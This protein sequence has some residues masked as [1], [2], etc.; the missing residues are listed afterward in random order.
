MKKVPIRTFILCSFGFSY[1]LWGAAWL[2]TLLRR[3]TAEDPAVM[4]LMLLGS[5]GPSVGAFIAGKSTGRYRGIRTFLADAFR[6][7]TKWI[8]YLLLPVFLLLYYLFPLLGGGI[9]AGEPVYVAAL[10]LPLMLFGGGMEEP[11]WRGFLFPEIRRKFGLVLISILIA[12]LWA[13]WHAP[14]FFIAGSSQNQANPLAFFLLVLGMA[15]MQ[16]VLA[17]QSGTIF[18]SILLHCLLNASQFSFVVQ[19]TVVTAAGMAA[20][21]IAGSLLIRVILKKK[22]A[23]AE[24][25]VILN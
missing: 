25:D 12:G 18:P 8:P 1:L 15:F 6:V 5:F 22:Q 11:G 23:A 14:L 16:S 4:I 20:T 17:E 9:K 2:I 7:K 10:M 21:M 3:T 13:L 24:K 19:E